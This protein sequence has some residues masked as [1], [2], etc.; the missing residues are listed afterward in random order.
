MKSIKKI[1]SIF[2]L[3]ALLY[4][5]TLNAQTTEKKDTLEHHFSLG[6]QFRPKFEYRDG[7]FRPLGS[8]EKPAD[9]VSHRTRLVFDYT[10]KDILLVRVSPQAVG[11]WGQAKMVQ[12]IDASGNQLTLFET[13][14]QIRLSSSWFVRAGRQVISLDDERF[15]GELDWAQGA[16]SHDALSIQFSKN[17]FEFKGFFELNQNYK[18]LFANNLYNASDHLYNPKD[19]YPNKWMQALWASFPIR[20]KSKITVLATNLGFQHAI[21]TGVG[22]PEYFLLTFGSNYFFSGEKSKFQV[23]GYFQFGHNE[24]GNKT[25]AY[26]GTVNY[27]Y[28]MTKKWGIGIGSDIV[29]GNRVGRASDFNTGFN[30][31]FATSH[32][33]YGY[34]DYFYAS[35]GHQKA[36]ISDNYIKLSYKGEK[37]FGMNLDLHQF[38]A[39]TTIVSPTR[40]YDSNLGQEIDLTLSYKINKFAS[41]KGG[42]SCYLTTPTIL[43][44]K[45]P[46][47]GPG[48]QQWAWVGLYVEPTLFK[49]K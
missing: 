23:A 1:V 18:A 37:G 38:F 46:T 42:Y 9:L 12:G 17:K 22:S 2:T 5:Q 48:Y 49:T 40:S 47:V 36:G 19:A 25:E 6:V 3:P 35:S 8:N 28:S 34:M 44:L 10:Y 16:R 7:A 39:P 15:F 21:V 29:S 27:N 11:V 41:V 30:P 4:T 31:Y 20:E 26:M 32:K 13:W 43:F 33:F 14:A 45:T 24:F